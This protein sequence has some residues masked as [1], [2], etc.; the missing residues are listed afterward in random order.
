M[1]ELSRTAH[2]VKNIR[3]SLLFNAV[4]LFLGF[5]SRKIFIDFLGVE[6]LGLNTMVVNLLSFLN[7][8]ELGINSAVSFTL[9]AP[10]FKKDHNTINEIV[11]IQGWLYRR[12]AYFILL[13][14]AI[15]MC[16]FPFIFAKTEFPLWYAYCSFGVLLVAAMLSYIVNYQQIVLTASQRE[17]EITANAQGFR[18]LKQLMQIVG[19]VFLGFGYVYW[20]VVEL[21]GSVI[22][23]FALQRTVRNNFPWLRPD[24]SQGKILALKYP[25]IITKTKQLFFHKF[26]GIVL[27][28]TSPLIIYAFLSLTTVA[29]YGN[30]ML[31][32]V[33]ITTLVGAIFN[34]VTASVGSLVAERNRRKIVSFY[35]EY[36]TGRYWLASVVCFCLF[37]L[38]N[39]F[40]SIWIGGQYLLDSVSFML[41]VAYAFIVLTRTNEIFK[42]AYGL[43]HDIYAP[44]AE[45]VLNLGLSIL[46]G[47]YWGLPGILSGVLISL[48]L[49]VHCWRPYF[50]FTRGFQISVWKYV[51]LFL[52]T[53]TIIAA[54]WIICQYI[55]GSENSCDTL[56]EWLLLS[57][58][59]LLIYG[60]ISFGLFWMAS[61][62]FRATVR[63]VYK[64]I[65]GFMQ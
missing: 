20:L 58:K 22:S 21:A 64:I 6:I 9:Y 8:A 5:F 30:Y 15:L 46:L 14:G 35:R 13:C 2:A 52:K 36:T 49:V 7:L 11:A 48:I 24:L 19:I 54:S 12:V 10:L 32:I 41:L 23:C 47:Y 39:P 44:V 43:F 18:I 56:T 26:A 31:L 42:A 45:A 4:V 16:F 1:S 55:I 61:K 29:I 53:I 50:L 37:K 62:D 63:R 59:M 27:T 60:T 28:Q 17:Y 38:S 51:V 40:I 33:S 3:T 34:G 65:G 57:V 25:G